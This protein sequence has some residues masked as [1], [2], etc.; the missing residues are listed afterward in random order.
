MNI[1]ALGW[2]FVI[3][4]GLAIVEEIYLQITG[5]HGT[6]DKDTE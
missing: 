2:L 1:G 3:L 4:G 5:R 6:E